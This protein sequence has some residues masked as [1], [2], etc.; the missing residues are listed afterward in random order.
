MFSVPIGSGTVSSSEGTSD[1]GYKAALP[2]GESLWVALD[3]VKKWTNFGYTAFAASLMFCC[4]E[5]GLERV[6]SE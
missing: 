2:N 1:L 5:S 3:Y 6:G 4:S